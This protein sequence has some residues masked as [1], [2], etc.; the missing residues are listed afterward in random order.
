MDDQE[1]DSTKKLPEGRDCSPTVVPGNDH[2]TYDTDKLSASDIDV[3]ILGNSCKTN[4]LEESSM[5]N[6][7]IEYRL[8]CPG[9]PAPTS[10][11]QTFQ[12]NFEYE[13]DKGLG[14][15]TKPPALPKL[16]IKRTAPLV[17]SQLTSFFS[18]SGG[19]EVVESASREHEEAPADAQSVPKLKLKI[20]KDTQV[21][22]EYQPIPKL[23][24]K[25]N[26]LEQGSSTTVIREDIPESL[27]KLKLKTTYK[28][29]D[30][31]PL[32]IV[33]PSQKMLMDNSEEN[34]QKSP[35]II[36]KINKNQSYCVSTTNC[37]T[38]A[39][40]Q[41][42]STTFSTPS[43][44]PK[45]SPEEPSS[46]ADMDVQITS[47]DSHTNGEENAK[48]AGNFSL[49]NQ[50]N[51]TDMDMECILPDEPQESNGEDR[52]LKAD[53]PLSS[54][55]E[56]SDISFSNSM[57]DNC[58]IIPD[59]SNSDCVLVGKS[60]NS[61]EDPLQVPNF[62]ECFPTFEGSL[63]E[64]SAENSVAEVVPVP[65]VPVKRRR[66]RPRKHPLP[67]EPPAVAVVADSTTNHQRSPSPTR[68]VRKKRVKR[69]PVAPAKVQTSKPPAR[70]KFNKNKYFRQKML[71]ETLNNSIQLFEEDTR[72]SGE[73]PTT[74]TKKQSATP[75]IIQTNSQKTMDSSSVGEDS[76]NKTITKK[77]RG[78]MEVNEEG[79][80][81]FT[82]DMLAEYDWP[83]PVGCCPNKNRDTYMLQEQIAEH[84][85]VKSFKRKYPYLY[86]RPVEMEERNYLVE[87]K[88]VSEKMSNL[89]L[90]AVYAVDVLDIMYQ[91]FNDKYEEY[92]KYH[93]ERQLKDSSSKQQKGV[94]TEVDKATVHEKALKSTAS[95]N[96]KFNKM[97]NENR[98]GCIDLQSYIIN[99]PRRKKPPAPVF[100]DPAA[101]AYPV[102]LI[103]GQ[104]S[105]QWESYTPASLIYYPLKTARPLDGENPFECLVNHKKEP[106]VSSSES[107]SDSGSDTSSMASSES[108]SDSE[109]E[110]AKDEYCSMC[111][112]E[113]PPEKKNAHSREDQNCNP[114]T[115]CKR[116]G[117]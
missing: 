99:I 6:K 76:S 66:G 82:V 102:E 9:S 18:N 7:D 3:I 5:V 33:T 23:T 109:E 59:E 46:P 19:H 107:S 29:E 32:E 1:P 115:S 15:E 101:T 91:D 65:E 30:M 84:L 45:V 36:L 92:K 86:R 114:C 97:R 26:Y 11:Y 89:G 24:I 104:Y 35:R 90:T 48:S 60:S 27:P 64:T 39:K 37:D 70:Q 108:F 98:V 74:S 43:E 49:D 72:M 105:T 110:N 56:M 57:N 116:K 75:K 85:G 34:C 106:V 22:T 61:L 81:E 2:L 63:P 41:E 62:K 83:P 16:T 28:A 88:L 71:Q 80:T 21:A 54:T 12:H 50:V 53:L 14:E 58:I 113:N 69:T 42:A 51:S 73:I 13:T 77:S 44:S 94:K 31:T 100:S 40:V 68:K 17:E 55:N 78:R 79:G 8:G 103:P 95:W 93:R 87:K 52:L 117:D 96:T 67:E 25:T 4:D 20:T 10:T 112:K 47:V 111:T 38:P